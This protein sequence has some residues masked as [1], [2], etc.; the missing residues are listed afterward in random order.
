MIKDK[1]FLLYT[2]LKDF[3][4]LA[5]GTCIVITKRIVNCGCDDDGRVNIISSVR[6]K[7]KID[8]TYRRLT[9]EE[10]LEFMRLLKDCYILGETLIHA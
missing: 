8:N 10:F 6:W 5:I 9:F 2:N 3:Y 7:P 1:E 4:A